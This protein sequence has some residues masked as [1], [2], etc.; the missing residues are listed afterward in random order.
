M[1][2]LLLAGVFLGI[3]FAAPRGTHVTD[4]TFVGSFMASRRQFSL[5]ASSVFTGTLMNKHFFLRSIFT[6]LFTVRNSFFG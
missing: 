3:A 1:R 5:S 6:G 2:Q 4:F